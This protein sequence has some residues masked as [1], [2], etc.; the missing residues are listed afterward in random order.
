MSVRA[1][2]GAAALLTVPLALTLLNPAA[3]LRGGPG[4]D[5]GWDWSTG[6][7]ALMGVLLFAA[8]LAGQVFLDRLSRPSSRFAAVALIALAVTLIWAELAVDGVSQ[9][10]AYVTTPK[11]WP[12]ER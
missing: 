12:F 11:P 3:R 5:G 2:I 1:A 10:L 8:G 9:A 6:S 7:F 4:G